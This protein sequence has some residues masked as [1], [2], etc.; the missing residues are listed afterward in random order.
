MRVTRLL[1]L[2]DEASARVRFH[3]VPVAVMR[4][5][6]AALGRPITLAPTTPR[7]FEQ[8]FLLALADLRAAG[9]AGVIFGNIHLAD[10]RAWYEERVHAAGLEHV[11]PLWG[12]APATLAREVVDLGYQAIITCIEEA[13]ADPAWLGQSLSEALIAACE[14]RGSDP[15]GER[16]EYHTLVC[17]GPLM[18]APLAIQLGAVHSADGFRQVDVALV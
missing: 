17:A 15:C 9:F 12:E 14:R 13:T 18:R 11:E 16:G 5:Q 6:A 4:A 7:T 3:G 1:T 8:V 10:V 2:Y